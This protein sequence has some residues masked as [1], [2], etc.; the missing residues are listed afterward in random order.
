MSDLLNTIAEDRD[1]IRK[2]AGMIPGL[3][4]FVE[5]EDRRAADKMVR[6]VIAERYEEQWQRISALQRD[7]ISNG[8]IALLDDMESA[9]IKLRQFIDRVRTA[10]YGYGSLFEST[11]VN[12]EELA[13]VAQFDINLLN[14][15]ESIRHSIDLVETSTGT[16]GLQAAIRSL[17]T[18]A[19]S[20]IDIYNRR[21]EV[22][23][24]GTENVQ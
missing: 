5:R 12:E 3:K 24:G 18:N 6:T 20:I 14:Q 1:P 13:K 10:S 22:L 16:D 9:A 17:I 15:I 7:L 11:K 23:R 19:Q 8:E 4:S 21:D 2:L